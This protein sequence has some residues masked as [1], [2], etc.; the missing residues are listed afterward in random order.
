MLE[1]PGARR[2]LFKLGQTRAPRVHSSKRLGRYPYRTPG[3]RLPA[4][5]IEALHDCGVQSGEDN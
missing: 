1:R 4:A 2:G 3:E 5:V